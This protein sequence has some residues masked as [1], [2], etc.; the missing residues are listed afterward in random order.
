ME[1]Q[2][3]EVLVVNASARQLDSVTRR[4]ANELV[5]TLRQT[6]D[7]VKIKNR[8]VA[9]GMPFIDEQW[10]NA[11]FTTA[12]ERST[13]DKLA[14]SYSDNLVAEV[15]ESDV[16]VIAAPMYNFSIPASLKAW[17]DQIARPGLTFN[18][19]EDGPVGLLKNKTAYVVM[20]SGG[21][22]LGSDIDFASGYL[23]HVLDFIGIKD[24]TFLSAEGLM[25]DA[26]TGL[27]H[28]RTQ[29]ENI[30]QQVA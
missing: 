29:I 3:L 21:T 6:H 8:D 17:I 20:A 7:M 25:I 15:Q 16:I 26:E 10:V 27:Q 14:L 30:A 18:Y 2:S 19:T 4:F 12:D 24:V 22:G 13:A 28:I 1:K 9:R 23:R 5:E 11:S